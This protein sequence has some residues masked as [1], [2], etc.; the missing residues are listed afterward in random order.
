[1]TAWVLVIVPSCSSMSLSAILLL[2]K[3]AASAWESGSHIVVGDP[4]RTA[5]ARS[6]TCWRRSSRLFALALPVLGVVPDGPAA[7]PHRG[8]DGAR[9]GARAGPR[10]AAVLARRAAALVALLAWAWWPSGQYQPVRATD[11]GT[12]VGA[13]QARSRSPQRPRRPAQVAAGAGSSRRAG[14]SPSR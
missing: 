10:G 8:R 4:R 14:T 5:T 13:V 7:R 9:A 6:S 1:M 3:L 2:P 11:D 12:L